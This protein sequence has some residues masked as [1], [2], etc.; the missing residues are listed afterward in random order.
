[1]SDSNSSSDEPNKRFDDE[2]DEVDEAQVER[3]L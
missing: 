1:M 3:I 2:F